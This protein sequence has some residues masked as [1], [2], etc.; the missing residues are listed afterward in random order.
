MHLKSRPEDDIKPRPTPT[1]AS[2]T[3]H[4]SRSVSVETELVSRRSST[5]DRYVPRKLQTLDSSSD[6][7][8][9]KQCKQ[10]RLK[11]VKKRNPVDSRVLKV[12]DLN[13]TLEKVSCFGRTITYKLK[14]KR[15]EE[16]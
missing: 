6:S 4:R 10:P 11:K 16:L 12:P 3:A 9:K 7:K 1:P 14:K 15:L 2:S 8:A 13:V 5:E